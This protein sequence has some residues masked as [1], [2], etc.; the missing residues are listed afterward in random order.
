MSQDLATISY[1]LSWFGQQADSW[2]QIGA[3]CRVLAGAIRD[4]L[5]VPNQEPK[6]AK[7]YEA[8]QHLID[9]FSQSTDSQTGVGYGV[10][11]QVCASIKDQL[12]ETSYAY[13]A[14]EAQGTEWAG[15]V[16]RLIDADKEARR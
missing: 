6:F 9:V 3:D 5:S 12:L 2:G 8:Y 14:A 1:R 15:E 11:A 13:A 7:V 16:A 4:C 10:A